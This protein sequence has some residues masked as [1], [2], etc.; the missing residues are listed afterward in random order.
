MYKT[1]FKIV[2]LALTLLMV[3]LSFA[4]G[5]DDYLSKTVIFKVKEDYRS[6]TTAK[7]INNTKFIKVFNELGVT[8]LNKVFPNKSKED[9]EGF[10]D[11]SLIYELNYANNYSLEEAIQRLK[12]LKIFDYVEP[13]YLPQL[14]YT[15]SDTLLADQWYIATIN[16]EN[17]WN[18][19]QGDTSIVIGITDTGW[20]PTHPDLLGS[21]K[22]NYADPINGFD[23]DAD[24]YTD[25]YMG[26]DLANNDNDALWESTG[27]GVNVTGIAAATT[28]NVTGI[29]GVGFNTRFLPVKISNAV[30]QLTHAYQGVIYAADHGADIINCSW[31]GYTPS[32]FNKSVI[33]YAIIN[34]G[35]LVV[36][37]VGN[38]NTENVFYPAGYPGVLSV[39][40]SLQTDVKVSTSNH[41]YYVDISAPGDNMR[42]TGPNGGYG[43]NGGTSMAAPVVSGA[44]AILKTQFPFYTNQQIAAL[45]QVTADD[46][47]PLNSAYAGKI[48]SGRVNLFNAVN[49]SGGEFMS[50]TSHLTNDNNNNIYIAGDTIDIQ[51]DFTNYLDPLSGLSAT[52]SS[53][54]PYITVIDGAANIPNAAT[55]ATVNNNADLFQVVV[56]GSVPQNEEVEFKVDLT[57]GTF[58]R[59]DYFKINLNADYIN[60]EENLVA[61]TITSKGKIGHNDANNSVG[62]GFTYNAMQLLYEAGFMIGDGTNRVA[63]VVRDGLSQN[64]GL[65]STY[66]VTL[67]PP[68]KSAKD[69]YG[70][71]SDYPI[72]N[73]MGLRIDHYAYAYPNSPDDKYIIVL[74]KIENTSSTTLNNLYAGIFAD[75]DI[76]NPN[77]N[78]AAYDATRKMGYVYAI[79]ND[80]A[81]AA[82]KVLSATPANNY[83]LDLDGSGGVNANGGGF[84][85]AE[86]YTTLSTPRGNAGGALGEDVAHVVSTGPF[87]LAPGQ[88][89]EIAFALIGGDSLLDI[90]T[91]ADAAQNKFNADAL[92]I[93]QLNNSQETLVYPN[94]TKGILNVGNEVNLLV[95]KNV[96][97]ETV[98]YSSKNSID[99]S[100]F[101]DGVYFVEIHAKNQ[102][103]V[104]KIVLKK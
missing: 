15:P 32:Q 17:A 79:D 6:F 68:F 55:L 12:H 99:L 54:S 89:V 40:G 22:I 49:A 62:L 77:L 51:V 1:P 13:H 91:S 96:L 5:Q 100:S 64:Q 10:I 95:I 31:G 8:K 21:V 74:Y 43:I 97:G 30:G 93:S 87:T 60:L 27:H 20:D 57:N 48:G 83:S 36:G 80:S 58:I 19:S 81:Y 86:K 33:D 26:W 78:K 72:S 82:I 41:G 94:P 70:I 56:G 61:T 92:S 9:R 24:G 85:I 44:A 63:D 23:D 73:P 16:A 7:T 11:L 3:N 103:K 46:I 25:N 102:I 18:T 66:N 69:L 65:A 37:A 67:S 75:W 53:S 52:L 98:Y 101:A 104:E 45:L 47:D 14:C 50:L 76:K 34:K 28:D 35:C 4:Q 42:T 29:A 90:Q 59:T 71:F 88:Q 38:D 39:A 2:A 84:T